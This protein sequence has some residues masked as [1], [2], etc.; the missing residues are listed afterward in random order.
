M[1]NVE[2]VLCSCCAAIVVITMIDIFV[3][4]NADQIAN[5]RGMFSKLQG[6]AGPPYLLPKQPP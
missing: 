2:R 4:H 1:S 6:S 5:T 3:S